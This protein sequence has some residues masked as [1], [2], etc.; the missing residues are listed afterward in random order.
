[1]QK[2]SKL[3]D[4]S[5]KK[6]SD[7]LKGNTNR[8]GTKC[9]EET[10][11]K[12]RSHKLSEETKK[13]ISQS[14][15]GKQKSEEH[16]RNSAL[17]RTGKKRSEETKKKMSLAWETR[18]VSEATKQK[19][20]EAKLG[21]KHSEEHKNKQRES[22][23]P[24]NK[25]LKGIVGFH[26]GLLYQSSYELN[27]MQLLD[28]H[29]IPYERADNKK[30]RVKY[31]FENQ[32]HYYYPDFYLPREGSIVEIKAS[33]KLHDLITQTKLEAGK[34]TFGDK[35]IVVTEKELPEL[36]FVLI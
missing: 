7:G 25:N 36:K 9:S 30:F 14:C 15:L 28:E 10:K 4:K 33:W 2:G 11:Q 1:M 35:F 34:Q 22:W 17:A 20:R 29:K 26:N 13:K 16:K 18:T 27:F 3:S 24:T 32:E 21:K 8:L 12:L 19:M 31:I 23:K 5:K 6:I